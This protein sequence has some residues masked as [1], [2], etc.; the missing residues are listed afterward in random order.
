[1]QVKT[2]AILLNSQLIKKQDYKNNQDGLYQTNQGF[3]SDFC[4]FFFF[5]RYIILTTSGKFRMEIGMFFDAEWE[6]NGW[7]KEEN[8]KKRMWRMIWKDQGRKEEKK[9]RK[10]MKERKGKKESL[11]V[12]GE[13]RGKEEREQI[14]GREEG[15]YDLQGKKEKKR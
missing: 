11:E 3:F 4:R 5:F 6:K 7:Y 15:S 12:E 10:E 9:E 13:R 14:K 8:E 2:W 1:M